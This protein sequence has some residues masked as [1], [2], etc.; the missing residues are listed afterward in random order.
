VTNYFFDLDGVF[1]DLEHGYRMNFG[2]SLRDDNVNKWKRM[3]GN[4]EFFLQ[5]PVVAGS[6]EFLEAVMY[7]LKLSPVILTASPRSAYEQVAKQKIAWVK[8][9][10]GDYMV[11]PTYG[12]ETKVLWAKPGD[13]LL[14]DHKKN[15]CAWAEAGGIALHH[16]SFDN[17]YQE[18]VKLDKP[19]EWRQ[20]H[21]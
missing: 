17:S 14:D 20:Q 2:V 3:L 7:D 11:I 21:A 1:A 19:L 12:S 5:L 13:V 10:L 8:K 9:N 6:K 4:T 18:L 16:T 15:I